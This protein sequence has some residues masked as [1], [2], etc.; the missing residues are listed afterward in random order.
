MDPLFSA[1][2]ETRNYTERTF[3]KEKER[4]HDELI[5]LENCTP[6]LVIPGKPALTEAACVSLP[7]CLWNRRYRFEAE[8][9]IFLSS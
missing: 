9:T 4:N 7:E 2:E 1:E 5:G 3:Q 8:V 6:F